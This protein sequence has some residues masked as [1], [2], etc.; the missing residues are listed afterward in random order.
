MATSTDPLARSQ[1]AVQ[2]HDTGDRYQTPTTNSALQLAQSLRSVQ[3]VLGDTLQGIALN[4]AEKQRAQAH[5]DALT[6]QGM[7]LSEAVKAGK[8]APTQNPWYM[9]AYAKEGAAIRSQ[10]ALSQLQLDSA[11]WAEQNDPAAFAQ[12]W[13]EGVAGIAKDYTGK[14]EIAGFAPVEAQYTQQTLQ[15]NIAHNQARI[16][17]ERG[18]NNSA[19]AANALTTLAKQQGGLMTADEAI[20]AMYPAHQMFVHTGGTEQ[21]WHTMSTQAILSAASSTRNPGLVDLTKAIGLDNTAVLDGKFGSGAELHPTPPP[22]GQ[23]PQLANAALPPAH[24]LPVQGGV[25]VKGGE[26][27]AHRADGEVHHGLDLAV[28][29]GTQVVS[30]G[31]GTVVAVGSDPSSGNFVKIDHGGGLVSSYAHLSQAGVA[32][33]DQVTPGQAIA[34]S[35][36]TGNSSGPHVHWRTKVNGVDVNPQS[37][38]F[39]QGTQAQGAVGQVAAALNAPPPDAPASPPVIAKG[40]SLF[41][42]SG[43]A[44]QIGTARYR[45]QQAQEFDI[46]ERVRAQRATLQAKGQD[47]AAY[48][49]QQHGTDLLT[50]NYDTKGL[51]RELTAQGYTAQEAGATLAVLHEDTTN[52]AGVMTNRMKL[53]GDDPLHAKKVMDLALQGESGGYTPAYEHQVGQAVLA[54]DISGEEGVAMVSR[55]H[56]FSRQMEAEARADA[57][58]KKQQELADPTHIHSYAQLK[59][60]AAN[61]TGLAAANFYVITGHP[62]GDFERK[63]VAK[64]ISDSMGAY[65][66]THQGDYEGAVAV[67][68]GVAATHG[69]RALADHAHNLSDPGIQQLRKASGAGTGQ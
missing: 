37:V 13:R 49:Y 10:S 16:V 12:K 40:P 61:L 39:P 62:L 66:T 58:L 28:P 36:N 52:S 11:S 18:Q 6:N 3:P 48:L 1:V 69:Q 8:I 65:L 63:K 46:T 2:A 54:G 35:G 32:V 23:A 19:L 29:E 67:G 47:G 7:V 15:G 17:A 26:Y 38:A 30:P 68:R 59:Q 34:L 53:N 56:S 14:D 51:I 57:R 22:P 27:A 20:A 25:T 64:Q 50:G 41:D 43:Q 44:E 24:A 21:E 42:I 31:V 60:Q 5:K 4:E 9:E 45:I 33:G 55:A